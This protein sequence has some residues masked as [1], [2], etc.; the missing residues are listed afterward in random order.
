MPFGKARAPTGDG[1]Q[2]DVE[3][4]RDAAH[5][6]E[7]VRVAGEPDPQRAAHEVAER[8]DAHPEQLAATVLRM[9]R[10]DVDA[11]DVRVLADV[12]LRHVRESAAAKHVPGSDGDDDARGTAHGPKRLHVE[13][14]VVQ[15][16]DEERI[17]V[18][19]R[20][21]VRADRHSP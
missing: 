17:D 18:V 21:D 11:V 14:V 10:R 8:G 4:G 7:E 16:R 20:A 13:V 12:Q 3:V 9:R 2:R 6:V 19:K 1:Q 5:P 15:V